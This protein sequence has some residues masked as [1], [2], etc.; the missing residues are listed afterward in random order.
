MCGQLFQTR[1][2][3]YCYPLYEFFIPAL[4]CYSLGIPEML[5][6]TFHSFP[7]LV[8]HPS[9]GLSTEKLNDLLLNHMRFSTIATEILQF[10]YR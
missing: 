8:A 1:Q 7:G 4:Y 6:L 9:V 3:E 2:C 10:G 5:F